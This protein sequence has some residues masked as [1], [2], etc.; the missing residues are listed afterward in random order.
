MPAHGK[1]PVSGPGPRRKSPTAKQ[2]VSEQSVG[3][4]HE[5]IESILAGWGDL[6]A[7][8]DEKPNWAAAQHRRDRHIRRA[9]LGGSLNNEAPE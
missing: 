4:A 8:V 9:M 2:N 7:L 3:P 6:Y 1:A 5:E